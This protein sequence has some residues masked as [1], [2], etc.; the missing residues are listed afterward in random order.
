MWTNGQNLFAGIGNDFISFLNEKIV[1]RKSVTQ[2][3][4]CPNLQDSVVKMKYENFF[5]FNKNI[6]FCYDV[7]N[8]ACHRSCLGKQFK[9]ARRKKKTIYNSE[10]LYNKFCL[11][12]DLAVRY[13]ISK[14]QS[15][16]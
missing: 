14:M 3:L 8:T 13:S 5:S 4:S 12:I 9:T 11:S 6:S 15:F 1:F 7:S 10:K 16:L 2:Q